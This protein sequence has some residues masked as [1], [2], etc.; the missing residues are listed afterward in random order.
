MSKLDSLNKQIARCKNCGLWK[1]RKKVVPGEGP[2]NARRFLIGQAPGREEN[3]IGKPFVGLAGEFLNEQLKKINLSREKIFLTGSIKC[4][5]PKNRQPKNSELKAC[6]PWL[7]RQ[8]NIIKP[9]MVILMGN[10][11]IRQLLGK[12]Q[13]NRLHGKIFKINKTYYFVTFHPSAARRFP[14]I[15][16]KF[17]KDFK[18]LKKF[19]ERLS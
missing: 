12:G 7:L 18:K 9:K 11:A 10:S 2:E 5:P 4:F 16:E 6:K 14:K 1:F 19:V 3:K 8:L 17:E 13:A 15:K